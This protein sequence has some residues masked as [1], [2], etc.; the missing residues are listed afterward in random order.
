MSIKSNENPSHLHLTNFSSNI[1][2]HILSYLDIL[3]LL[4]ATATS[5][6]LYPEVTSDVVWSCVDWHWSLCQPQIGIY[7]YFKL[8]RNLDIATISM[9]RMGSYK[10]SEDPVCIDIDPH[11]VRLL[12][13]LTL[14]SCL[15][16]DAE[17]SATRLM[18]L[19]YLGDVSVITQNVPSMKAIFQGLVLAKGFWSDMKWLEWNS[20]TEAKS[21]SSEESQSILWG[22]SMIAEAQLG[23]CN[24]E[25]VEGVLD[26]ICNRVWN[27]LGILNKTAR[28][29]TSLMSTSKRKEDIDLYRREVAQLDKLKVVTTNSCCI[30][31]NA[32]NEPMTF[33]YMYRRWKP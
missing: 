4:R 12:E 24:T 1:L 22:M 10:S 14:S 27:R 21:V 33:T 17:R 20:L 29:E 23:G 6:T 26:D 32:F 25:F 30:N 5:K 8:R 11:L 2:C 9:M 19:K 13:A 3:C 18:R 15:C 28:T 16:E 31:I 7:N